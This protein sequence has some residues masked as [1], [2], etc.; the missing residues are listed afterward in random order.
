MDFSEVLK[1]TGLNNSDVVN[2]YQ[3][4]SR[5][6]GNFRKD[7][8]YD[9]IIIVK[10][11]KEDQFS[12]NLI[13]VNFFTPDG[14]QHRLNEHEISALECHF[15]SPEYIWKED[16]KYSFKLDLSKLRHSLSAKSS[17]SWVKAKK[18]LT[19]ET[20]KGVEENP[21]DVGKKSLF[22]AFR[23]IHFGIQIAKSGIIEDYGSCNELF[24]EIMYSYS[25]WGALFEEYK[26]QYNKLLTD[27]RI[28]APK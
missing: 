25:D 17:N 9:F 7:S 21:E 3:Y 14:H 10:N 13:N 1:R 22:H 2:C 5:V 6:Y 19:V 28:L 11:K 20:E 23:I 15:L 4:G 24:K 16:K 26:L 12:D 27:F 18:K 8:D